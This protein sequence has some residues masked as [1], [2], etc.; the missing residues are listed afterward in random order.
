MKMIAPLVLAGAALAPAATSAPPAAPSLAFPIACVVGRSCE[1]Q[2]YVDRVAGPGVG[3]YRCGPQTYE[4]HNG[5]DIRLPDMAAQR[6]GVN[7]LAAAPGRVIGIRDG[8]Q[9]ISV[10]APGAPSVTNIECGNGVVLDHG[11]EWQTQYCHMAQGSIAVK[12]GDT[13]AA[14]AVLGRVGLSGNTEYPHLH[15]TVRR[16][17]QVADPFAPDG[18][19]KSCQA[20]GSLWNAAAA[21]QMAYRAGAILNAG[22][23]SAEMGGDAVEQA[24]APAVTPSSPLM[25]VYVRAIALRAGDS[26]E[27]E[28]KGPNGARLAQTRAAPLQRWRAQDVTYIG[29]RRPATGWPRGTYVADYR[30]WRDGKPA[31]SRRIELRL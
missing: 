1:V 23:A 30:V 16:A 31:L 8:V 11:G 13:V 12:R 2:H 26:V 15:F 3:D 5:V 7:V 29:K 6:R 27:L 25:V 24:R 19:G 20:Q 21:R 17:G 9:D 28:L 18:S 14:G 4:A 22:F 10:R